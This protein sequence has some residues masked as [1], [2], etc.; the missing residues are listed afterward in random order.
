MQLYLWVQK[1]YSSLKTTLC[2][3]TSTL[4]LSCNILLNSLLFITSSKLSDWCACCVFCSYSYCY[5]CYY[6]PRLTTLVRWRWCIFAWNAKHMIELN[7]FVLLLTRNSMKCT[8]SFQMSYEWPPIKSLYL[9][10]LTASSRIRRSFSS[11]ETT[12][13]I[14]CQHRTC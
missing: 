11:M 5:S 13:P 3:R 4:Y 8:A 14:Y 10:L 9:P 1:I 2:Y 6:I 12:A 7:L